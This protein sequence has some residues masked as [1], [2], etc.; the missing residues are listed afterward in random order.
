MT[1]SNKRNIISSN[2]TSKKH[3]FRHHHL[4][5]HIG[6][7]ASAPFVI[8]TCWCCLLA[9]CDAA[10][11]A[12]QWQHER[13]PRQSLL[14]TRC[15]S[16]PLNTPKTKLTRP[17]TLETATFFFTDDATAL[18]CSSLI[19]SSLPLQ[20]ALLIIPRGGGGGGRGRA[21]RSPPA[22]ARNTQPAFAK[23]VGQSQ[24]GLVHNIFLQALSSLHYHWYRLP[25]VV[26]FFVS[27]NLGN[28]VFYLAERLVARFL[29][30][31]VVTVAWDHDSGAPNHVPP[32]HFTVATTTKQQQQPNHNGPMDISRISDETV[33]PTSTISTQTLDTISFFLGYLLH[34]PAQHL[35]HAVLVYGL[36]TI[37]TP[38][39]YLLTL[40]GMYSALISASIG[41]TVLNG[42]LLQY[43]G[44]SKTTAFWS[45][46]GVFACFNYF[47]IGYLVRKSTG[48]SP[49][50][51]TSN[52]RDTRKLPVWQS[53]K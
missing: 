12:S 47:V 50:T 2:N 46:L 53:R 32:A 21:S 35:L 10:V 13:Q 5:Y 8:V 43:G 25:S 27:G 51:T 7:V 20:D 11:A 23:N 44:M 14:S 40:G 52:P 41:S 16:S 15:R 38:R 24:Q 30:P 49:D 4:H 39:K 3:L 17:A 45:T 37:N 42:L 22:S 26:R 28:I 48:S 31:R 33:A 6:R 34:V 1:K 19:R 36:Q 29:L 18:T 9:F